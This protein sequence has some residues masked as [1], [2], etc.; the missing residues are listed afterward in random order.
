VTVGTSLPH[1]PIVPPMSAPRLILPA[2]VY[3][4]IL[5]FSSVPG[6]T[7]AD[8]GLPGWLSYVGHAVEYTALGAA[9]RWALTGARAPAAATVLVG[10]LL[11]AADEL[12]QSTVPGRETSLVDLA[13]DVAAVAVGAWVAGRVRSADRSG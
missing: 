7:Y 9:L 1:R 4:A 6:N 12:F 11:G 3:A 8:L 10:A 5:G 2:L 13:V